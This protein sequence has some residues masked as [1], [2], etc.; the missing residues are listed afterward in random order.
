MATWIVKIKGFKAAKYIGTKTVKGKEVVLVSWSSYINNR[1]YDVN[2]Y[3]RTIK[4]IPIE[5]CT[6]LRKPGVKEMKVRLF[7]AKL[8][9]FETR[10][11]DWQ[12][13]YQNKFK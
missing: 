7:F 11:W 12:E 2:K 3:Q 9:M 1:Y 13:E 8:F 4:E 6:I 10:Y 5:R